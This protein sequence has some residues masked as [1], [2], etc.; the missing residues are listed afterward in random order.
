[1]TIYCYTLAPVS[2][3]PEAF[4]SDA[5][6]AIRIGEWYRFGRRLHDVA[7]AYLVI[8]LGVEPEALF[9]GVDLS[10]T[11]IIYIDPKTEIPAAMQALKAV[12]PVLFSPEATDT[13][14]LQQSIGDPLCRTAAFRLIDFS[15]EDTPDGKRQ[16]E[17]DCLEATG[18][19]LDLRGSLDDLKV[20]AWEAL[21]GV[22]LNG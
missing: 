5:A 15:Y 16:L 17:A 14:V 12:G 4:E 22:L 8:H 20:Q 18:I 9:P 13:I 10:V 6:H 11:Q 1:M 3:V 7:P 21:K 2:N 19:D